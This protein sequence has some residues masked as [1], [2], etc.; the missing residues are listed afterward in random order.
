MIK[1]FGDVTTADFDS[2]NIPINLFITKTKVKGKIKYKL[3][4]ELFMPRKGTYD[5][6]SVVVADTREELQQ[7]I[8]EKVLPLYKIAFDAV[9]ALVGGTRDAFYYWVEKDDP[10]PEVPD[11]QVE[12]DTDLV[13]LVEWMGE[14]DDEEEPDDEE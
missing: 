2:A 14:D 6:G 12:E 1:E 7:L 3:T 11:D 13:D 8:Q 10:D 5:G 9:T 4:Y